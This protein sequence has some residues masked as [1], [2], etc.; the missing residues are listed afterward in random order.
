LR[1]SLHWRRRRDP[2]LS[3]DQ[4]LA[5]RTK[6]LALN[7]TIEA[8][9][10]GEAGKGFAVVA[11]EVKNLANRT[12]RATQEVTAEIDGMRRTVREAVPSMEVIARIVRE[13]NEN[14]GVVASTATEQAAVTEEITRNV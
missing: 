2:G 11:G 1:L 8:E 6:L 9:R 5:E 4:H 12:A 7:A 14:A 10:A 13:V 3:A